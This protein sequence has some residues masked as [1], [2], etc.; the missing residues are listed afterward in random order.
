[1]KL[2]QEEINFYLND[3]NR[4]IQNSP[5]N[6]DD[7]IK[8][9]KLILDMSSIHNEIHH[10]I[11][12]INSEIKVIHPLFLEFNRKFQKNSSASMEIVDEFL[13]I[14]MDIKTLYLFFL[15]LIDK[16]PKFL[17]LLFVK[18]NR[19]RDGSF[20]DYK[21]SIRKYEGE[22]EFKKLESIIQSY[23]RYH[24]EIKDFRD[25]CIVH[26][27]VNKNPIAYGEDNLWFVFG[28][29]SNSEIL[30]KSIDIDEIQSHITLMLKLFR[31]IATWLDDNFENIYF[32]TK[33]KTN[34][35]TN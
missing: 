5:L 28:Y 34:S 23:W 8:V 17:N 19:P 6:R 20:E 35:T 7:Q 22:E 14:N 12:R 16:L 25:D 29:E 4:K 15:I 18:G 3:F 32:E 27:S 1:V 30:W 21:K 9:L 11:K 13:L 2:L 10:V 26:H 31:D 24:K 33:P